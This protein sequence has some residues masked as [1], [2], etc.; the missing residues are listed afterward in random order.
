[1]N[2]VRAACLRA[3]W[4]AWLVLG[5]AT[6]QAQSSGSLPDVE[7]KASAPGSTAAKQ[8]HHVTVI[9]AADIAKS[10]AQSVSE[11]LQVEANL[12]LQSFYGR[13]QGATVDMR[14][15]GETASS[16]VLVVVDGERQRLLPF[17]EHVVTMVDVAGGLVR[18]DWDGDW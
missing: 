15:M 18:V 13:D 16:N 7:I 12:G 6:S 14:G 3:C 17:V 9:T 8:P 1:M 11:L 5:A 2:V 10:T 4:P